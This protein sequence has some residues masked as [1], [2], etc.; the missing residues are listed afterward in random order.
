MYTFSALIEQFNKYRNQTPLQNQVAIGLGLAVFA[1]ST[2]TPTQQFGYLMITMLSAA[3]VGDL[4]L[5]PAILS[6]PIGKF[7]CGRL[8]P[9]AE[10]PVDGPPPGKNM[11]TP[12]DPAQAAAEPA[13]PI[14]HAPHVQDIPRRSAQAS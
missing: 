14:L 12:S 2:F 5:L 7:F 9:T 13:H 1:T 4:L 11:L 3:L 8:A 6:G 10:P